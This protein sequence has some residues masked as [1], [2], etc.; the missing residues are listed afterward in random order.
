MVR[1]RDEFL[2]VCMMKWMV[3]VKILL[4]LA[5]CEFICRVWFHSVEMNTLQYVIVWIL[6]ISWFVLTILNFVL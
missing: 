2:V 5:F 1:P 4:I 3:L 6:V